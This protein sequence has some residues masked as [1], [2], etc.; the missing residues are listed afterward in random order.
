MENNNKLVRKAEQANEVQQVVAVR[1][2][3]KFVGPFELA[4]KS[5]LR[6]MPK[7]HYNS[8][9]SRLDYKA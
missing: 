3:P 5:Y 4:K 7:P 9:N 8:K 6:N 1:V 2:I